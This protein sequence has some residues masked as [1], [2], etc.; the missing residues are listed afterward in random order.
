MVEPKIFIFHHHSL[1]VSRPH[2]CTYC[3][4][5]SS[6]VYHDFVGP[7]LNEAE[8]IGEFETIS[9]VHH[10]KLEITNHFDVLEK[11]YLANSKTRFLIGNE[12]TIADIYVSITIASLQSVMFDFTPWPGLCKWSET[13]KAEILRVSQRTR[14]S[15]ITS[16][17]N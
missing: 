4:F 14:L 13:I 8:S 11:Q 3:F 12:L 10:A 16:N 9:L 15:R 17:N 2:P 1:N 6:S 5:P 7:R